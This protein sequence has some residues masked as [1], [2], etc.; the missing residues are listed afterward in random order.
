[1]AHLPV[2]ASVPQ[3]SIL[4][5]LLFIIFINVLPSQ[6]LH[7]ILLLFATQC[8]K[9]IVSKTN[10]QLL[11]ND[12]DSLNSW[13]HKWNLP[14][15]ETKFRLLHFSSKADGNSCPYTINGHCIA[16]SNLM[17]FCLPNSLNWEEHYNLIISKAYRQLSL[18]WRTFTIPNAHARKNLYLSLV[19]SQLTFCSPV[20]RPSLIKHVELLER[21]QHR[22]TKFILSNYM[23]D[24]K[25][26]LVQLNFF[27]SCTGTNCFQLSFL[28][29]PKPDLTYQSM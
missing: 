18:L 25:S 11:Q 27:H 9:S 12:L 4:G 7:S 19:R 20:W 1:M 16:P 23:L 6:V 14:F 3:G 10:H 26:R 28:K 8:A 29:T 15:N 17:V 13:S 2:L 21:V 22:A 24:Y 5:P